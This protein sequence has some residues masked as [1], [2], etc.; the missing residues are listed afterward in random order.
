MA[1]PGGCGGRGQC[2]K[3]VDGAWMRTDQGSDWRSC[4]VQLLAEFD[5]AL[6][7]V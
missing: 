2:M 6:V 5:L 7:R 4:E 3:R 1:G